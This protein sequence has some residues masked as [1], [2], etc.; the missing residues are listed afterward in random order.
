MGNFRILVAN[1]GIAS[2]KFIRSIRHELYKNFKDENCI[3]FVAL[4]T[5]EDLD[6]HAEYIKLADEI[7]TIPSGPS[8]FNFGNVELIVQIAQEEAVQAV[9]PG[10][11]HASENPKLP[12]LLAKINIL[13]LGPSSDSMWLLGDKI[14]GNI[15][16]QTLD[17]PVL[18][19]SG[20]GVKLKTDLGGKFSVIPTEIYQECTIHHSEEISKHIK[21]IGFPMMLKASNG[22]GGKGIRKVLHENDCDR[23]FK[24]I[25]SEVPNSDVLAIKMLSE[26]RHIEVQLLGDRHGNV[27]SLFSRDCS[28]QR[29]H[30]KVIEEAPALK[31][32][33]EIIQQMEKDSV[34]LAKSVDYIGA[35]TVEYLYHPETQKYYFLELNARLQVEHTCTELIT[36]TNIA[37]CQLQI[38]LGKSLFEI[39][40][41][42][43]FLSNKNE[44]SA[45]IH[46]ISCRILAEC[47]EEGF[48]PNNGNIDQ[49][50]FLGGKNVWG[51][52]SVYSDGKIH[53]HADSQYGHIFSSGSNREEA[54]KQLII[55]LK[56]LSIHGNI[57]TNSDFLVSLLEQEI[58]I[59]NN[60]HVEWLDQIISLSNIPARVDVSTVVI[61]GACVI[62]YNKLAAITQEYKSFLQKGLV[63]NHLKI[64]ESL[65]ISF[66]YQKIKFSLNVTKTSENSYFVQINNSVFYTSYF[67]RGKN[68]ILISLNTRLYSCSINEEVDK[69]VLCI[70][71]KT[72][73]LYKDLDPSLLRSPS[74]GRLISILVPEGSYVKKDTE[75]A[76]IEVMKM[77]MSLVSSG[78]G[79]IHFLK[80]VGSHIENGTIIAKLSLDSLIESNSTTE[81]LGELF[82]SSVDKN[83]S[84][85]IQTSYSTNSNYSDIKIHDFFAKNKK[86]YMESFQNLINVM[87]GFC[88]PEPYFNKK[89]KQDLDNVVT[90]LSYSH[91]TL[92]HLKS[93]LDRTKNYLPDHIYQSISR[94]I[95][96][97]S[98]NVSSLLYELPVEEIHSIL[99]T[100]SLVIEDIEKREVF[101]KNI[102][103]LFDIVKQLKN[104]PKSYKLTKLLHLLHQYIDV[105][106]YFVNGSLEKSVQNLLL[107]N[108]GL[109]RIIGLIHSHSKLKLKNILAL[110]IIDAISDI[111]KHFYG[112]IEEVKDIM[113]K[114]SNLPSSSHLK[115]PLRAKQFLISAT[116]P[117]IELRRNQLESIFLSI[118]SGPSNFTFS[119]FKEIIHSDGVL[120]D[121]LPYFFY[122]PN[123]QIQS[124]ALEVYIRR[125]YISHQIICIHHDRV[126]EIPFVKFFYM[127]KFDTKTSLNH[128]MKPQAC[129][130]CDLFC[131]DI[132]ESLENLNLGIFICF[133]SFDSFVA[134]FCSCLKNVKDSSSHGLHNNIRS[135]DFQLNRDNQNTVINVCIR[136]PG[137][138]TDMQDYYAKMCE[139]SIEN[140][141]FELKNSA[142]SR[143]TIIITNSSGEFPLFYTYDSKK[144][145][146]ENKVFRNIEPAEEGI[147]EIQRMRN[148]D[149][150]CISCDHSSIHIYYGINKENCF[151]DERFFIRTI[152]RNIGLISV[153]P[154][155]EYLVK[156]SEIRLLEAL[157]Q[158][159]II[160][161]NLNK[162]GMYNHL[163]FN[164]ISCIVIDPSKTVDCLKVIVL[165]HRESLLKYNIYQAEMKMTVLL[166]EGGEPMPLRIVAQKESGFHLNIT[167][168]KEIYDPERG[169]FVL[170]SF[171]DSLGSLSNQPVETPY[172][173]LSK[174]EYKRICAH[175]IGTTYVY[176]YPNLF[177]QSVN[178]GFGR[179]FDSNFQE[180]PI[181]GFKELVL[182][183]ESSLNLVEI[184][185]E[186]ALN[187]V[188]IVVWEFTL[189]DLPFNLE[190]QFLVVSTDITFKNGSFSEREAKLYAAACHL[191][192]TKGIPFIFCCCS[193]GARIGMADEIKDLYK[194]K[195]KDINNYEKGI[196]Y[197]YLEEEDYKLL[198]NQNSVIV[199]KIDVENRVIY[200]ILDIIGDIDGIG[201]ENLKG[202]GLVA[203][204]MSKLYDETFTIS[205]VTGRAVGIG[206]YLVRLGRRVIQVENS[207]II[208]TGAETLNR[209]LGKNVYSSHEQLGGTN[210]MHSNGVAQIVAK[211]DLD[212]IRKILKW[213]SYYLQ[214]KIHLSKNFIPKLNEN[215]PRITEDTDPKSLIFGNSKNGK[216]YQGFFDDKSVF[217]INKRWSST[218]I[219]GRAKLGGIPVSFILNDINTIKHTIPADPADHKDTPKEYLSVGQ[220]LSPESSFK[221]SQSI[222]DS[223]REN[224]PL[225]IFANFRGFSAGMKDM[226]NQV[227]KFGAMIVDSLRK[228]NHPVFIYIM[229]KGELRGG[230]W[231]VLDTSINPRMIEIYSSENSSANV[232]EPSGLVAVKYRK[233]EII[234]TI[235]RIEAK[236]TES[237]GVPNSEMID[238]YQ[239]VVEHFASLHDTPRRMLEKNVIKGIIPWNQSRKLL[240][241]RL[242]RKLYEENIRTKIEKFIGIIDENS[243]TK[244]VN[245]WF[246]EIFGDVDY[247]YL[248]DNEAADYLHS[249]LFKNTNFYEKKMTEMND[250]IIFEK[251]KNLL[252]TK[253]DLLE[254]IKA[255]IGDS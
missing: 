230:S 121:L 22:G 213:L 202:S 214:N 189:S 250:R 209:V 108:I 98:V 167:L 40:N 10:W 72:C 193:N 136:V 159:A 164:F 138:C 183:N 54:R 70:D 79:K 126:H 15:I 149:I 96:H 127:T 7:I 83:Q 206:A 73:L 84:E 90:Y 188:G 33:P 35:G 37:W 224:L 117:S 46:V 161:S 27:I 195:W 122:S 248:E 225:F 191:A 212:G 168:Y 2:L 237:S 116:R 28:V 34:K 13:F 221:F 139:N 105:E 181:C 82:L 100:H 235:N 113:L 85:M 92:A 106:R 182:E 197:L 18:P 53:D 109:D 140:H 146:L 142:I 80:S 165:K 203:G 163:F 64:S 174:L 239:K 24:Q 151:N 48:C 187:D 222:D 201:V 152:V 30:Q 69:F 66:V 192:R 196:D 67:S 154:S 26:S 20:D 226:Y 43:G 137:S 131:V 44:N 8:Q 103:E 102:S 112:L 12:E 45:N 200:K 205:L 245:S 119:I 110:M 243:F 19:W 77:V 9:W 241:N 42:N 233:N 231:A 216:Y 97:Y 147:L 65:K 111:T 88:V 178:S 1:N 68:R 17:I 254:N 41:L 148:F 99:E 75:Y 210:I 158:L 234:K 175:S 55:A 52:F 208:L 215:F 123:S 29:R 141:V 132:N 115:V 228:Y 155:F 63:P 89:V 135:L 114:L 59:E 71:S 249:L 244:T 190:S 62:A 76:E 227:L 4:A 180:N 185:R 133:S 51:Y 101:K 173:P 14:S 251:I 129:N 38:A 118:I 86:I 240:F 186:P 49:I 172:P 50:K 162:S 6:A 11:G 232:L 253:P 219:T 134:N 198:K 144:S 176:D 247:E 223:N 56:E 31:C 145:F 143:V 153:E 104:G 94:L 199:E 211:D 157:D 217:E 130:G 78:S 150:E 5:K 124:L 160:T 36:N 236:K 220:V 120:Y 57:R 107:A 95:Y 207:T 23:S 170:K 74:C 93:A 171:D 242:R 252:S 194:V 61:C 246:K 91:F 229:P 177:C 87:H 255:F 184:R 21:S 25:I 125:A 47:A 166:E 204:E 16:A 218:V 128:S 179:L 81:H 39:E 3:D 169:V 60:H 238:H 58:F 156:A 32:P